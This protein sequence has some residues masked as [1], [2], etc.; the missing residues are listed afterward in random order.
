M[1]SCPA[2]F[3]SISIAGGGS[4]WH[5]QRRKVQFTLRQIRRCEGPVAAGLLVATIPSLWLLGA[6]HSM[7]LGDA[8]FFFFLL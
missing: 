1:P 3:A 8:Q 7:S 4:C 2:G 5:I 6:H